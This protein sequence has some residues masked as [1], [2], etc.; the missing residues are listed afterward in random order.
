MLD[1]KPNFFI[2]FIL[3]LSLFFYKQSEHND[4]VF[5]KEVSFFLIK[6]LIKLLKLLLREQFQKYD[7]DKKLLYIHC[8]HFLGKKYVV[9]KNSKYFKVLHI[10]NNYFIFVLSY[11][12]IHFKLV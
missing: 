1:T 11:K 8:F 7:I 2:F 12:I 6:K 3:L 9:L 10:S 4:Q 5:S